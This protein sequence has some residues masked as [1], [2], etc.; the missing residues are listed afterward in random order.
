MPVPDRSTNPEPD[1]YLAAHVR[2]A[3]AND[4]RVSEL[5]VEVEIDANAV[6]LSGTVTSPEQREAASEVAHDLVPDHQ[7]RNETVVN[8]LT[9]PTQTEVIP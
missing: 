6:I 3:L 8:D 9:E 5:G 7:V 4:P 1:P 2:E